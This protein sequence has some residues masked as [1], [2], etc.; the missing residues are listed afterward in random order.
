MDRVTNVP[1]M[2]RIRLICYG[3]LAGLLIGAVAGWMFHGVIGTI[4][5]LFVVALL[6]VPVVLAFLF[7]QRVTRR[8]DQPRSVDVRDADWVEIEATNR[9]RQ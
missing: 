5:R 2:D 1:I 3:L 4:F 8:D 6:L 7:W 9:P